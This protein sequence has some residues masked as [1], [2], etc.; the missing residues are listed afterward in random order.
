[1]MGGGGICD[2][3]NA[4]YVFHRTLVNLLLREQSPIR[5]ILMTCVSCLTL[6]PT[7]SQR[8]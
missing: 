8:F 3:Q 6:P 5:D 2:T 4:T 1:M 7:S